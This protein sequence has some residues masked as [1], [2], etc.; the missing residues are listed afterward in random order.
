M[1]T[2]ENKPYNEKLFVVRHTVNSLMII[3]RLAFRSIESIEVRVSKILQSFCNRCSSEHDIL[4][5]MMSNK[6][7]FLFDYLSELP[8]QTATHILTRKYQLG[9]ALGGCSLLIKMGIAA[10]RSLLFVKRIDVLVTFHTI[11]KFVENYIPR[12][13]FAHKPFSS[14]EKR[15]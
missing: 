2:T 14:K 11:D 6:R 9:V 10:V 15:N 13:F 1:S 3:L 4:K 8:G 5:T 12:I 7:A